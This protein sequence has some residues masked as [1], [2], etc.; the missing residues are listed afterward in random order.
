MELSFRYR[1]Y[2]TKEQEKKIL[3]TCRCARYMYNRLLKQRTTAYRNTR[4]WK[5][6]DPS[7][8][9]QQ[10]PF[11]AEV[12]PAALLWAQNYLE[13]AF[14]NFFALKRSQSLDYRPE[15]IFRNQCDP[16]YKLMIPDLMGYPRL[17]EKKV[18]RESYT[19]NAK[20]LVVQNGRLDLP[21]IGSVKIRYHRDIPADA[22]KLCCTILKQRCGDYYAIFRLR[23][24]DPHPRKKLLSPIGIV[25]RQGQLAVRSDCYPVQYRHEDPALTARIQKAY[26]T[27]QRRIPGSVRYE[28]QRQYLASL[29]QKRVNQRRDD[30]HKAALK[31]VKAS[32]CICLER[33]EVL[34]RLPSLEDDDLK[35][36]LLDEA[37][38]SF[39]DLIRYKAQM[40]GKHFWTMSPTLPIYR[41]CSV[42]E[43]P[44]PDAPDSSRWICPHCCAELPASLNA[45]RNMRKIAERYIR[46]QDRERTKQKMKYEPQDMRG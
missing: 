13:M 8:I 19:T 25:Y 26:Q 16:N 14:N 7:V 42:C 45:A 15:S 27:L 5:L 41:Y 24:P 23:F 2:P 44:V 36:E 11:L 46:D 39:S 37:W 22:Q 40:R 38:W 32:D 33:P 17:K 30:L 12:D 1:I 31:I 4:Q 29:Y 10:C 3:N 18:T 28:K 6:F 20:D 35:A 9:I 43:K 34:T 21:H